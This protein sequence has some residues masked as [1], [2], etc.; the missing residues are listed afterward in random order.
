MADWHDRV[1]DLK[2]PLSAILANCQ[3]LLVHGALSG[4]DREVVDD[5]AAS[6]RSLRALIDAPLQNETGGKSA[7]GRANK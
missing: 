1:H 3:Y 5:I 2:N 6:A 7:A 4:E